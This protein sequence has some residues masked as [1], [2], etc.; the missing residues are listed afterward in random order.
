MKKCLFVLA[1]FTILGGM[2]SCSK[3]KGADSPKVAVS[4]TLSQHQKDLVVSN[5]AFGFDIFKTILTSEGDSKNVFVSPL[6]ISLALA[7][8]YNGANGNTKTEMQ[9]TLRFPTL[10]SDEIN[11]YFQ[12]L[13]TSLLQIDPKVTLGI[14]NSIWYRQGFFVLP[15]FIQV[16][17]DYYNAEVD[18]LDFNSPNAVNTINKWASDKTNARIPKVID[19]IDPY[20][21]MFLMNAIYFKGSWMYEFEANG[22]H[23]LGFTI[24]ANSNVITPLMHQKGSFNYFTNDMISVVEMPY[25]QGNFT[26]VVLLPKD[27]YNTSDIVTSLS[28]ENWANW[29][30]GLSKSNVEIT[31]PRFKFEYDRTLNEDLKLL[32]MKKAFSELEADYTNINP[33]GGLFISFVKHNSFVE[34]NETGTEAAAVTVVGISTTSYPAQ[35]EFIPFLANKPF[36][37]VIRETTTNTII[38]LG[39]VSNPK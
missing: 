22:T 38:F 30:S 7:M 19:Q 28:S 24:S 8:T 29:M 15:A 11:G 35:P 36:L 10:A 2:I 12:K 37:F 14:A 25:G 5:N 26:M 1:I 20:L 21:V 6:S 31:F 18:S 39:R 9:N 4:I 16:N 34:V 17:K 23:D 32:G 13:S 3:N 33:F 27:G